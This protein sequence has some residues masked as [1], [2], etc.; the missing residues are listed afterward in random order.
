[1]KRLLEDVD[2]EDEVSKRRKILEE[3]RELDQESEP[4]EDDERYDEFRD[5]G[6]IVVMIQSPRMKMIQLRC[7]QN[8]K[9]LRRKEL[10]KRRSRMRKRLLKIKKN[11]IELWLRVIR[12]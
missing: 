8:Y 12:C 3:S 6:L 1:M 5:D 10:R 9:R 4:D 11:G 7:M 2:D